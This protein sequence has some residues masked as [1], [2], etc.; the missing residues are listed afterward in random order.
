MNISA[1]V[2]DDDIDTARIFSE[3]LQENGF[4]IIGIGYSG[5]DAI[6]LY[7][8]KHPNVIF[9]DIMMPEGSGFYAIKKIKELF[10]DAKIIAVTADIR[11]STIE[12]LS[13]MKIPLVS[14]P[15]EIDDIMRLI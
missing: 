15:F 14:K 10:P 8:L 6:E 9:L 5:K 3:F 12:K 1:I 13:E 2:V 11:S 4:D 7:K